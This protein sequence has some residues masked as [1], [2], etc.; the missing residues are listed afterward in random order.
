MMATSGERLTT[1]VQEQEQQQ[2]TISLY[3]DR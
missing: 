1:M 2:L 3:R